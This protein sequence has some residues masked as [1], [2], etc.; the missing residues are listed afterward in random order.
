MLRITVW[1]ENIHEK[2]IPEMAKLHP[3]GLHGTIAAILGEDTEF[4]VRTATL[5]DPECGLTDEVLAETEA[6][7]IL[8]EVRESNTPAR[9]L[10]EKLGFYQVGKR[11][12]YY[13]QPDEAGI[14]MRKE[15]RD[16]HSGH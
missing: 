13:S 7:F 9:T 1:N 8:L 14:I 15:L 5:H 12:H 10:Y 2:E 4:T 6:E 11:P 16:E 3:Q